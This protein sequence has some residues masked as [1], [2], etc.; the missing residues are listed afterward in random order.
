MAKAA[1]ACQTTPESPYRARMCAQ[2]MAAAAV[3]A[4]EAPDDFR[5]R[6]IAR[7]VFVYAH[8]FLH[9]A[10]RAKNDLKKLANTPQV[11]R[12]LELMLC[13]FGDHDYGPYEQIR[14][15]VAAHRQPI[16]DETRDDRAAAAAWL[17]TS[18]ATVRILADDARAIWNELALAYG[19]PR[20]VGFP[21]VS[22]AFR[23]ALVDKGFD[24]APEGLV[25]GVGS[26][27]ATRSDALWTR[28]G[29][30]LAAPQRELV[31]AIRSTQVLSRLLHATATHEPYWRVTVASLACEAST[32]VDLLYEQPPATAPEYRHAPLLELARTHPGTSAL[33]I[34]KRGLAA[35]DRDALAH[36]RAL[37][38]TIGAH[39]DEHRT[40]DQ[41]MTDLEAVDLGAFESVVSNCFSTLSQARAADP[42]LT[43]LDMVDRAFADVRGV[44]DPPDAQY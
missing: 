40:V 32:L 27:D 14:H 41:L 3:L 42:R 6:I 28:K 24:P 7:S 1:P 9:W 30:A 34:L 8:E 29:G 37:R 4:A 26:F 44:D 43:I 17:D 38:N 16:G 12:R 36:V 10:R 39:L 31:D 22:P 11:I 35:V 15:R 19:M 21:S 2:F 5:R 13:R 23:Q 20:L 33:P 18:D 25:L